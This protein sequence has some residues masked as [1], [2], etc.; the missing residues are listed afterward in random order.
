MLIRVQQL[1]ER[2]WVAFQYVCVDHRDGPAD[3]AL[4]RKGRGL[5]ASLGFRAAP[6]HH[7]SKCIEH[8]ATTLCHCRS[9]L[10]GLNQAHVREYWLLVEESEQSTKSCTNPLAPATFPGVYRENAL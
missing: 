10:Q 5:R 6:I 1:D 7:S 3:R 8:S 9:C 4:S 2:P